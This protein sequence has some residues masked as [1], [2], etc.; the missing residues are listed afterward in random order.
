MYLLNVAIFS[1]IKP[2]VVYEYIRIEAKVQST[3]RLVYLYVDAEIKCIL[4]VDVYM[5]MQ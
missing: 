1:T 4:Y 5:Y 3:L 2:L